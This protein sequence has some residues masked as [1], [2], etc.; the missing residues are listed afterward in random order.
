MTLSRYTMTIILLLIFALPARSQ[1]STDIIWDAGITTQTPLGIALSDDGNRILS[2]V[3]YQPATAALFDA[4]GGWPPI[5]IQGIQPTTID[6]DFSMSADGVVKVIVYSDL[7]QEKTGVYKW[8]GD[9]GTPDWHYQFP[10]NTLFA[11]GSVSSDGSKIVACSSSDTHVLAAVFDPG[12]S[13]PLWYFSHNVGIAGIDAVEVSGDGSTALVSDMSGVYA[14]DTDTRD[15][16]YTDYGA[17][18]KGHALSYDGSILASAVDFFPSIVTVRERVGD[19]FQLLW[20]YEPPGG[21]MSDCFYDAVDLSD[22]GQTLVIG[23]TSWLSRGHNWLS[24]FDTYDS[25]PLWTIEIEGGPGGGYFIWDALEHVDI[26]ADGSRFI[27][28]YWG[29]PEY[30]HE[31][32]FVFEKTSPDP[33]FVLDTP[34]SVFGVDIT[35]DGTQAAVACKRMHATQS[36]YGGRVYSI[37]LTTGAR[38]TATDYPAGPVPRDTTFSLGLR[39]HNTGSADQKYDELELVVSAPVQVSYDLYTGEDLIL[40]PGEIVDLDFDVTIPAY[41]PTGTYDIEAVMRW[42]GGWLDR[43]PFPLELE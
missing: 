15:I 39:L 17:L 8:S 4:W 35:P 40:T 23:A 36:G 3:G 34:G 2:A 24:V 12:S 9:N 10:G 30:P 1:R 7:T 20:E 13:S 38:I 29:D 27:A 14:F 5:W 19:T 25:N 11:R 41:A 43:T 22:D 32:M 37:D 18:S 6:A 33:I 21:P 16:L 31:E 28:G 26:S 42:N